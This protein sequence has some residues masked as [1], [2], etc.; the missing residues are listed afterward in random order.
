MGLLIVAQ[1]IGKNNA[2][3]LKGVSP[4]KQCHAKEQIQNS[5]RFQITGSEVDKRKI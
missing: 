4:C 2:S 5:G 3:L 1:S